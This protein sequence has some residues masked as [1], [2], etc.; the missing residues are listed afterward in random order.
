M[1]VSIEDIDAILPQ[2]QC[3]KCGYENCY[4]YAKALTNGEKHNLCLPGGQNTVNK[5]ANMLQR[6]KLTIHE[7]INSYQKNGTASIDENLCIGCTKCLSAC[8]I[9]AIIG[10]KKLMHT[11]IK[12]E[13]TG[14]ELCLAP[15]PMDCI[16][17]IESPKKEFNNE[18]ERKTL[19]NKYNKHKLRIKE[20][21]EYHTK[22]YQKN[23]N[24]NNIIDK[25]SY[26]KQVLINFKA[27]KSDQQ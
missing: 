5:L 1:I 11:V 15:C 19:R 22:R 14:C 10:A 26:I 6:E 2:I 18:V 17:I 20:A 13:C 4:A 8:P 24:L 25:K 7:N 9:D 12:D 23:T 3:T 27:K 16:K 21:K